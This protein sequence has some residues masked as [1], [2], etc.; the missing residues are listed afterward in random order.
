MQQEGTYDLFINNCTTFLNE[1]FSEA[2]VFLSRESF[3]RNPPLSLSPSVE[4]FLRLTPPNP[5]TLRERLE[6]Y[7]LSGDSRVE[8]LSDVNIRTQ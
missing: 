2:G 3:F 1:G 5:L 4:N 8:Q 6:M 7:E